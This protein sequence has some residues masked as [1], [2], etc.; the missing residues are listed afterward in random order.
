MAGPALDAWRELE[1]LAGERLLY[2]T[3]GIDIGEGSRRSADALE[4][5][6]SPF[7]WLA[8]E[9]TMER[10]PGLVIAPGTP[11]LLQ[12]S[13]GVCMAER[14][15]RAQARLAAEAGATVRE[16]TARCGDPSGRRRRR[17]HDHRRRDVSRSRGGGHGRAMGRTAPA[18]GGHRPPPGAVVRAGDVLPVGRRSAA[19]PDDHRLDRRVDA[20]PPE[21]R[22]RTDERARTRCPT[23]RSRARSRWRST[24]RGPTSMPTNA[25][26]NPTPSGSTGSPAGRRSA[27]CPWWRRGRRRRAS[28]P[29]RRTG[30]SCSTAWARSS[31]DRRA[32]GTGSS[33]RR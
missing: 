26:S 15:V 25:R 1:D 5:A 18:D 13:G 23:P 2:T 10:W 7:A 28:T 14:T 30:S 33:S 20:R 29:T 8:A 16:E 31:S 22:R 27:S 12:E 3:G 21:R 19:V 17:G 11:V 24:A 4:A 6:G 9:A 32:A